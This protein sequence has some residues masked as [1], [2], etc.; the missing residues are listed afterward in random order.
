MHSLPPLPP[1]DGLVAIVAAASGGSFTAA[2]DDLGLSH[3]AVS[4]RIQAVEVWLGTAL[5]ER[6]GRGVRLTP[7]GERFVR[8]LEQSFGAIGRQAEQ[9]RPHRGVQTVRISVLPSFARLWLLPRL[10]HLQG[11]PPDLF[12]DIETEYRLADLREGAIDVAIRYGAGTWPEVQATLLFRE[13]LTPVAAPALADKIGRNAH[14]EAFLEHPLVH[15]SD[16]SQWRAWFSA[17]GVSY[18][19]RPIDRR[20]EDYDLVLETAAAGAAVALLRLPL[21]S[22]WVQS[23]K[24]R[25]ISRRSI[26]NASAHF[27]VHRRGDVRPPVQRLISRLTRMAGRQRRDRG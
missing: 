10:L 23:G 24:L 21:A 19:P 14:P 25:S 18:R 9:W 17:A 20:F 6:H 16:A 26:P 13:R 15:D 12:L 7:A 3:S 1:L 8:T 22:D 5:F 4:R 11:D 27:A 2:A